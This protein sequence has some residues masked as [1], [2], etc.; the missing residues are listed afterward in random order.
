MTSASV[1]QVKRSTLHPLAVRAASRARSCSEGG[2]GAVAGP[3]VEFDDEAVRRPVEVDLEAWMV[4]GDEGEVDQGLWQSRFADEGQEPGLEL[5]AGPLRVLAGGRLRHG[6]CSSVPV[7]PCDQVGDRAVVVE[8][9]ALGLRER[10]LEAVRL[11]RRR[12]VQQRP[13]DFR[14]R[15][16]FVLGG[17]T[18][19]E[20]ARPMQ[21]D[22][23]QAGAGHGRGDVDPHGRRPEQLPMRRG[24]DVAQHR[25]LP[26][27]QHRRQPAPLGPQHPRVH[28]RIDG[29]MNRMQPARRHPPRNPGPRQPGAEQLSRRHH[30]P[31]RSRQPR[32]RHVRRC[33]VHVPHSDT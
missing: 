22:A 5:A 12:Q 26:A 32:N 20:G 21:A 2:S 4:G 27:G 13:G 7:R 28:H 24:T 3:A 33:A 9:Q 30:A 10:P 17:V 15:D 29:T 16:A 11:D 1:R 14:D 25:A 19:I 23:R 18:G 6:S 31:L 8:L